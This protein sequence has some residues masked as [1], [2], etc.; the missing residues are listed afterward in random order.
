M[1]KDPIH[2]MV[3][4]A[5]LLAQRRFA[6]SPAE[7]GRCYQAPPRDTRSSRHIGATG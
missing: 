3:D 5:D 2:L 1:A 7:E 6:I 4:G